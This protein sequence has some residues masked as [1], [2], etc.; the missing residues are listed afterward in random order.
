MNATRKIVVVSEASMDRDP[1]VNR[2]RRIPVSKL[3]AYRDSFADA[4]QGRVAFE[5]KVER[6][7]ADGSFYIGQSA[8]IRHLE[9][10][11][12][13]DAAMRVLCALKVDPVSYAFPQSQ[14]GGKSSSETSNLKSY[15]KTRE[16]C[17]T[18]YIGS[19]TVENVAKVFAVCAHKATLAGHAVLK[20]DFAETFL[21][22]RELRSIAQGSADLWNALDE[23]RAK[24]MTTGA[25]TQASQMIRTLVA[26]KS[27]TDVRD[28]RSKDVAINPDG[29][30]INALMRRLG[31]VTDVTTD[32]T[33]AEPEAVAA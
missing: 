28:G 10:L 4:V 22:S 2:A 30:I 8:D 24:H 32:A 21:S 17:E 20:R 33:D 23:I 31:Q 25:Q 12:A 11:A 3:T 1:L 16:L 27:A 19:A 6:R 18:V 13:S 14:E 26:L 5:S 9:A 15:K 29:L 7:R